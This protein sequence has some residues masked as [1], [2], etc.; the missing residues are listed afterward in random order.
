MNGYPD[1]QGLS[2]CLSIAG[3]CFFF[4]VPPAMLFGPFI[5]E[6]QLFA[7]MKKCGEIVVEED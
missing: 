2:E 6:K 1:I 4:F 3:L 5:G 7:I